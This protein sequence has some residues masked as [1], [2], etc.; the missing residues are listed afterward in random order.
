MKKSKT[1][2]KR[3]VLVSLV[4]VLVVGIASLFGAGY[5]LNT[6]ILSEDKTVEIAKGSSSTAIFK[7]LEQEKI[8]R[9]TFY[10]KMYVKTSEYKTLH[11]GKFTFTKGMTTKEVVKQLNIA[12]TVPTFDVTFK[13]GYW[14]IDFAAELEKVSAIKKDDFL[15]A[16][17]DQTFIKELQGKYEV[18]KDV[19]ANKEIIYLLEGYLHPETYNYYKDATAYDVIDNL[20]S[21]TNKYYVENKA[22]FEATGMNVN[23]VM[24]LASMVEMEGKTLEDRELVAGIFINR[25]NQKIALGSDVTTYYG[26]QVKMS[27]RDLTKAELNEDNGYNTRGNLIGLPVAPVCN[28]SLESIEA[29]I[30]YKKTDMLFFVSDKNGKIYATKTYDDH[31]KIVQKLKDQGLWFTY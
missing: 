16:M 15:K 13:E 24:T 5:Y 25:L 19:K 20:V 12:P 30:N 11:A 3:V 23:E 10:A 9:S 8:I 14:A 4:I 2:K 31:L 21:Y 26:Q 17:N 28:P 7:Q 29:V 27:E 6:S 18:L 22:K 1:N